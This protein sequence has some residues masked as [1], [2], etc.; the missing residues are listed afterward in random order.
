MGIAFLAVG[1]ELLRGESREGNGFAL[2]TALAAR[3]TRLR[4]A[5]TLPDDREAIRLALHDVAASNRLVVISGGLGPTDDDFTREAVAAALSVPLARDEAVLAALTERFANLGRTMHPSNARQADRPRGATLLHNDHGTAPG[6]AIALGGTLVVCLP[7][8]PR[9]FEKMLGDHLDGLLAR[10]G[11]ATAARDEVTLRVFGITESELQGLLDALHYSDVATLRSLPTWP[12][13]RLKLAARA[14]VGAF[15]QLLDNVREELG[16]RCYG[17]GDDDSHAAATLRALVHTGATLAVAE[18]CTGGTIGH[19][20]TDVPGC[21]RVLLADAVCYANSAKAALA[22]VDPDLMAQHGA[23]SESVARALA[24]G[25]RKRTGAAVAI[26]TTGIAGPDGGTAEK[27]VGLVFL[28]LATAVGTQVDRL[29]FTGV[30]RRRWKRLVA[31]LALA[32][33]RRW[34]QSVAPVE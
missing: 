9:E 20:L 19:L 13:I 18:S 6:F 1:D 7:G 24:E 11:I 34:A 27:P 2:A 17:E 22:N 25:I 23:V 33:L 32:K 15:R 5:R 31:H 4:E 28:A 10:A 30:E 14:D 16:W 12:E 26:A 21:S 3:G 8:V 29:T